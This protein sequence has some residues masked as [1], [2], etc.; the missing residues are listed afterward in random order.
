MKG[1]V[2]ADVTVDNLVN[3]ADLVLTNN[4]VNLVKKVTP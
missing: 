1:Y 2:N 4:S 3:L